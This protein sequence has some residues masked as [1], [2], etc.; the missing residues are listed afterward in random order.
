MIRGETWK[1]RTRKIKTLIH[2]PIAIQLGI[3]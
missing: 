1:E 3:M 2:I